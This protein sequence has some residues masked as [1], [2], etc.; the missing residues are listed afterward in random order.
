[1]TDSRREQEMN[2]TTTSPVSPGTDPVTRDLAGVV[3]RLRRAADEAV[4]RADGDLML[5]LL[6]VEAE[7]AVQLGIELLGEAAPLCAKPASSVQEPARLV[8]E[9]DQV[10]ASRPIEQWPAGTS[11]LI[12][13]VLDLIREHQL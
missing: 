13:A 6:S 11:E 7:Y 1:M 5:R 9:A 10:L 2:T 3:W 4:L 8:H 12:V